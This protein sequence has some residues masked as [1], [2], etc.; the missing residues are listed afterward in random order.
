MDETRG[1]RI[2]AA[3]T[4]QALATG[5]ATVATAC[6][7]CMVMLRDGIAEAGHGSDTEAP[8]TSADIA[9]LLAASLA[10][11]R[12]DREAPAG[13]RLT[14]VQAAADAPGGPVSP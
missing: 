3:R 4:D 14:V 5:A 10:P 13:R 1:T 7:Y 2:N 11:A 9:E 6:P 8:V 12:P